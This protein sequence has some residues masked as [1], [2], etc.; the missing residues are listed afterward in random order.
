MGQRERH[1]EAAAA[2][3]ASVAEAPPASAARRP[4]NA[5]DSLAGHRPPLPSCRSAWRTIRERRALEIRSAGATR[6]PCPRA[7]RSGWRPR[8]AVGRAAL[9][10]RSAKTRAIDLS[11]LT[12]GA[13]DAQ[14]GTLKCQPIAR[15]G[16]RQEARLWPVG[17]AHPVR[18]DE[19]RPLH[20][21]RNFGNAARYLLRDDPQGRSPHEA[22][23][24][25]SSSARRTAG[26]ISTTVGSCWPG[27]G[28]RRAWTPR[29]S[30]CTAAA[31]GSALGHV[32]EWGSHPSESVR[33]KGACHPHEAR[34]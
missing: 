19:S 9:R 27:A 13:Q 23:A 10:S 17:K 29:R 25:E 26:M 34:A 31:A 32:Q 16:T 1:S 14:P 11:M 21:H 33:E 7:G 22:A 2:P 6:P 28:I 30:A 24:L 8:R 20:R 18:G 15:D 3:P 4:S 12:R 5:G